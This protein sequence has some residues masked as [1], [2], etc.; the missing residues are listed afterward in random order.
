MRKQQLREGYAY[1]IEC[2]RQECVEDC[3]MKFAGHTMLNLGVKIQKRQSVV[4]TTDCQSRIFPFTSETLS[5]D[6]GQIVVGVGFPLITLKLGNL[7]ETV[8]GVVAVVAR[9]VSPKV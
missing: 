4:L 9:R 8:V 5:V 3:F 7:L 1:G 2:R 6:V